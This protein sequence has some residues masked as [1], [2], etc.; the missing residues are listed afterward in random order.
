MT[1]YHVRVQIIE[2]HD[3]AILAEGDDAL[4][5]AFNKVH[6]MTPEQIRSAVHHG[7]NSAKAK[8]NIRFAKPS[9]HTLTKS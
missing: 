9:P 5:H 4:I 7:K 1:V 6:D 3:L 2:T 8:T